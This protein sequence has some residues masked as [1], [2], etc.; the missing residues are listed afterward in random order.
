MFQTGGFLPWFKAIVGKLPLVSI[1]TPSFNAER[2]LE[3]TIR[4]VLA[5]D[6]PLLEY[7]VIDG[8]S[9]DGTLEILRSH[10]H[11]LTYLSAPDG[12]AADAINK[13]FMRA[14]GEILAWLGADDTYLLG[15]VSKAV[16]ALVQ[17]PHA[18]AI[19]GEGYWTDAAG[20]V[21]RRYPTAPYNPAMFASECCICQPTCFFRRHAFEAVGLLNPALRASFDYDLWIRLTKRYPFVHIPDYL[22]TS[23]MH[24]EN[25]TLGQRGTVFTESMSLLAQHYGYVPVKWIFGYLSFLRDHR[26]QFFEPLRPSMATYLRALPVG[27][28]Y[29][30]SH[31]LRYGAEWLSPLKPSN[32]FRLWRHH[33][34][35][36]KAH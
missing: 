32:L 11:Q 10:G 17:N 35:G 1:I 26:D 19:Y 4:S 29:N 2:F 24:R 3:D 20:Q 7:I 16:E 34:G 21:L 30:Y 36:P 6:Y 18:A 15:A 9:T 13:G 25:K 12:G 23:R 33:E 31:P 8:G 28:R 5:Q 22:A 27:M 14:R